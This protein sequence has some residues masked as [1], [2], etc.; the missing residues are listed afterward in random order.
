VEKVVSYTEALHMSRLQLMKINAAL[1]IQ[2]E[3]EEAAMKRK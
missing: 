1:D 3:R 2:A